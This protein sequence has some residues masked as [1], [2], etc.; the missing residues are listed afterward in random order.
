MARSR[1]EVFVPDPYQ[2][3]DEV[4]ARSLDVSANGSSPSGVVVEVFDAD[5]LADV[6]A[7]VMPVNNP[8]VN[9]DVITLPPLQSL[10]DG[11]SYRHEVLYVLGGNTLEDFFFIHGQR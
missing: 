7:T 2:G 8:T 5:T 6:T 1:R 3:E 11:V 10:T 9:G 4:I